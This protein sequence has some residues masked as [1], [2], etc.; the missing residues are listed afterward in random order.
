MLAPENDTVA[1]AAPEAQAF[2]GPRRRARR[3]GGVGLIAAWTWV[4]VII[5]AAV[6]ADLLPLPDPNRA[7][8]LA[9]GVG[10][11]GDHLFGTDEIGRDILTR[12]IY[13]ARIS[14]MVGL[15]SV[16]LGMFVGGMLGLL[17]GYLRGV[18]ER[19]VMLL[20]DSLLAFPALVLLLCLAAV[21]GSNLPTLITGLAIL[22]VPTFIRLT[23]ANSLVVANREYVVAARAYGSS[24]LRVIIR[25]VVPNV[26]MPVLAY[27]FVVMGVVIV[28]EGSLSFL[29]LGVPGP[30]PSWGSM[31]AGGRRELESKSHIVLVPGA[32]MFITVLALTVI[33]ERFRQR[34]DKR[35]GAL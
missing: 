14:L 25:D 32:V 10:P 12:V 31:I 6:F 11:N 26:S 30:T 1:L 18:T 15:V 4:T 3:K 9:I 28:A 29:G 35:E 19:V 33:G 34:Y 24:P 7:D 8:F 13:G 20:T 2:A 21:F 27:S 22:T 16:L 23:R 5:V 17:A